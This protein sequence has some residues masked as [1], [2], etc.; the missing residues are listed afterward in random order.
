LATYMSYGLGLRPAWNLTEKMNLALKIEYF[1]QN[2]SDATD[3][4]HL[5]TLADDKPLAISAFVIG[6]GLTAKF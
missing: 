6:L 1:G 2:F 3:A 5:T 4:G